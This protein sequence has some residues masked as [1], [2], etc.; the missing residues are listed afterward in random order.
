MKSS[1]VCVSVIVRDFRLCRPFS[2]HNIL[3]Y[4]LPYTHTVLSGWAFIRS[5]VNMLLFT[6]TSHFKFNK[7]SMYIVVSSYCNW[8]EPCLWSS[9]AVSQSG[10]RQL[11]DEPLQE[12]S[13]EPRGDEAQERGG[14]HPAQETETRTTGAKNKAVHR[15]NNFSHSLCFLYD[16]TFF[17]FQKLF[18]RRN[19]DVL[20]E[21]ETMFESPLVDSYLSSPVTVSSSFRHRQ[22]R[23]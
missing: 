13:T 14:G 9:R 3:F 23:L 8:L 22:I 16:P 4:R 1:A 19:V 11:Q 2:Y 12:Q 5:E 20:N 10:Q 17:S 7:E 6:F 21:D 15:C 18:K